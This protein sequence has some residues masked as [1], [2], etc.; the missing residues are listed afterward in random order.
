MTEREILFK[1]EYLVHASLRYK[2]HIFTLCIG[3]TPLVFARRG[4]AALVRFRVRAGSSWRILCGSC[5]SESKK[6]PVEDAAEQSCPL[7][8]K[9]KINQSDETPLVM[10]LQCA[11]VTEMQHILVLQYTVGYAATLPVSSIKGGECLAICR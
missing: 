1:H 2:H 6:R 5:M 7:P 8:K 9:S 10:S 4:T 11:E 3:H